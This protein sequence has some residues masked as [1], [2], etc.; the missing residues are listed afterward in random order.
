MKKI[1]ITICILLFGMICFA[2]TDVSQY[3]IESPNTETNLE[4][5]VYALQNV[6]DNK[7][8]PMNKKMQY[9][10]QIYYWGLIRQVYE[11]QIEPL[12]DKT[13]LPGKYTSKQKLHKVIFRE[14]ILQGLAYGALDLGPGCDGDMET[15][16][17]MQQYNENYSYYMDVQQFNTMEQL[18][19]AQAVVTQILAFRIGKLK[20]ADSA[21]YHNYIIHLIA[22]AQN[23]SGQ[24][25]RIVAASTLALVRQRGTGQIEQ[26]INRLLIPMANGQ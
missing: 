4:Y 3:D 16:T 15:R 21:C 26:L 12:D 10:E 24:A 18:S 17:Y 1:L 6:L 19:L 5:A 23:M 11:N 2:K 22:L 7:I 20:F 14:N 9:E 8:I 13:V 25:R